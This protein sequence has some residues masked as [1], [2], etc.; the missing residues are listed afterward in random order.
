MIFN[1]RRVLIV[2]LEFKLFLLSSVSEKVNKIWATL[3]FLASK[4]LIKFFIRITCPHAAHACLVF[5]LI[6]SFL[7]FRY[8]LPRDTAPDATMTKFFLLLFKYKMSSIKLFN[9]V[10]LNLLPF[11]SNDDPIFITIFF[12]LE[13]SDKLV[14]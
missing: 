2:S 13:T 3:I 5:I 1:S 10:E 12:A 9:H 4:C 6:F 14:I 8:F 7:I 11:I